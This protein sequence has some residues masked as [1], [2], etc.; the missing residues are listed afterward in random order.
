MVRCSL[1][2]VSLF[3]TSELVG[4]EEVVVSLEEKEAM[5]TY[6]AAL[7]SPAHLATF[8]GQLADKFSTRTR[9]VNHPWRE[10]LLDQDHNRQLVWIALMND[11]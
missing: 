3:Q 2:Y 8:I 5:V 9:A 6:L 11:P 10:H 7:T 4:V 1:L